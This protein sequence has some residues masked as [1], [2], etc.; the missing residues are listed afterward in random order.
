MHKQKTKVNNK[1]KIVIS[2]LIS[3]GLFTSLTSFYVPA[4]NLQIRLFAHL[5]VS[6]LQ[7]NTVSGK[8]MVLADGNSVGQNA[9]ESVFKLTLKGDSIQLSQDDK[10]LGNFIYI[11]FVG[12]GNEEIKVKLI[13]PD[14]KARIYENNLSFSVS[15]EYIRII[16]D[17]VL[18]NYIGG[19]TEAEA[20]SR[21]NLEFYKVQA[22]LA[23]TF[24]LTHINKHVAEGFSLCDQVHCQ[25]YYGKPKDLTIFKAIEETKGKVVVDEN[26]N[27]IVAAFHSNSGG[28]TANSE[29]V[30]GSRTSYLRSVSDSFSIKMPNAKWERRMLTDDWLTYLKLK[31]NV[32]TELAG[33]KSEAL[34]FKQDQRKIFLEC[35]N[36]RVPLKNIR[37]DL[38]LKSTFFSISEI[39]KDSVLF[40]GRGY[41]HGLGMCQEG[42]MRMSKSGYNYIQ[43]LNF[44][45][46]NIQL[47]DLHK[48]SFFKDE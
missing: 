27:L 12:N 5:K 16:N 3:V 20:G 42:A 17:V 11:K 33:A 22:I 2:I 25:A 44:Y 29:D 45:Y 6:S 46:K 4:E 7:L 28:Q 47:I 10:L 23:R 1:L 34:N 39:N 48:L 31:H 41:G 19:V 14:R 24:A 36:S 18:D 30:W 9:L 8:Y 15:E 21:S 26:L 43:I 40:K 38:Q 35:N 32:P 13:N 37:S